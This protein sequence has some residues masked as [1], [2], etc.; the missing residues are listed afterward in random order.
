MLKEAQHVLFGIT[1]RF[2]SEATLTRPKDLFALGIEEGRFPGI[3]SIEISQNMDSYIITS[4]PRI[5]KT[6]D[7]NN[8]LIKEPNNPEL[9]KENEFNS[10]VVVETKG[11]IASPYDPSARFVARFPTGSRLLKGHVFLGWASTTVNYL[12]NSKSLNALDVFNGIISV[13]VPVLHAALSVAQSSIQRKFTSHVGRTNI[14]V[15][16]DISTVTV[17]IYSMR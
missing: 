16:I 10:T 12:K 14:P 17:N 7:N 15:H 11:N 2:S 9:Q 1:L 4:L 5:F 3:Q 6:L 8:R 13:S